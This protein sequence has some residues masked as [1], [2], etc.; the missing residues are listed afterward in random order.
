CISQEGGK[1][2]INTYYI[3]SDYNSKQKVYFLGIG[4]GSFKS[5]NY[6]LKYAE[7]DIKDIAT[8]LKNRYGSALVLDT[9]FSDNVTKENV[10]NKIASYSKLGINDKLIISYSG[11]GMLDNE[12]NYF[13]STYNIDF[14]YPTNNGLSYDAIEKAIEQ[15]PSRYKVLF[16]DACNSGE[17]DKDNFFQEKSGP[18]GTKGISLNKKNNSTSDNSFYTMQDVFSDFSQPSGTI[19]ISASRG[20]QFALE[21]KQ[22]N[23]GA[24]TYAI[25][26]GL[27]NNKADINKDGIVSISEL[28]NYVGKKVSEITLGKQKPTS[29]KDLLD[30]DWSL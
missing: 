12:N 10:L 27:Q 21:G 5:S 14:N 23:N 28:K 16:L 1:S 17:I 9:L 13:L 4:A 11:H 3:K 2:F 29:R 19:V 25:I 15:L 7:K 18:T 24:F 6:N 8:T 20:N 26:Q 22:W 30:Y